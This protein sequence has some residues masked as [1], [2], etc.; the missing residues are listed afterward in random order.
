[1]IACFSV[2]TGAFDRGDLGTAEL[3]A[4]GVEVLRC[5][6][7]DAEAVQS[8]CAGMDA[9]FHIAAKAGVWGSWQSF[10]LPNVIGTRHILAACRANR[11]GRLVYT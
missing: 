6:L 5:D 4:Q 2:V 3:E 7:S 10:Y 9:V 11:I 8:A 1:M